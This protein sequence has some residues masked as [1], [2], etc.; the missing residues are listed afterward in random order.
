[1]I[2]LFLAQEFEEIEALAPVDILRR[3][4]LTVA[5]VGVG[6]KQIVGSH[7]VQVTAD[8][9]EDDVEQDS[10]D[11]VIL[12]GGPGTKNLEQS[13]VM[14]RAVRHCV[15]TGRPVAAICAAPSILGH[16]GLLK[17]HRATCFPGY[18]RELG[19]KEVTGE[20]VCVS[21]TIITGKGAGVALEFALKIVEQLCGTEKSI[22]LG[23]KLQ[24]M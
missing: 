21:G 15:K 17:N 18:E 19:A 2:Y 13:S 4:G 23:K 22:Q 6:G 3:A 9:S 11:M 10:I 14:Q 8:L 24:C 1:M 12:P 5:T 20:G 7:G 16:M